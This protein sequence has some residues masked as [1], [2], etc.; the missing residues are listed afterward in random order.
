MRPPVR[1]T[2]QSSSSPWKGERVTLS[3]D[4]MCPAET[5]SQAPPFPTAFRTLSRVHQTNRGRLQVE[6]GVFEPVYSTSTVT[7]ISI[8]RI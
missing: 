4:P 1:S 7:R 3:E 8:Q 5:L 6:P 2:E